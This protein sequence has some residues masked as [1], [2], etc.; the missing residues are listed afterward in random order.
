MGSLVPLT[1]HAPHTLPG[2]RSTSGHRDQS[3][4]AMLHPRARSSETAMSAALVV[5]DGCGFYPRQFRRM[6]ARASLNARQ[7]GQSRRKPYAPDTLLC[8]PIL[9]IPPVKILSRMLPTDGAASQ[10]GSPTQ[11]RVLLN[12]SFSARSVNLGFAAPVGL[13][14][15]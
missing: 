3:I 15:F 11:K 8:H 7:N 1:H 14:R 6:Q 2:V 10:L 5:F 12:Q 9:A 4:P 13:N